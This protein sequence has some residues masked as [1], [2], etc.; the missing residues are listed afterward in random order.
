MSGT[1]LAYLQPHLSNYTLFSY[2][3]PLIQTSFWSPCAGP[4]S[5]T[6][7]F[8]LHVP[9]PPLS[10]CSQLLALAARITR[11]PLPRNARDFK[12]WVCHIVRREFQ[13][14]VHVLAPVPIRFTSSGK[15]AATPA[16]ICSV[17]ALCCPRLLENYLL[18]DSETLN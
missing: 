12:A 16:K 14:P 15:R 13:G 3:T 4:Y 11:L 8:T 2:G 6:C 18:S 5:V 17:T 10:G 1:F 7:R 9:G